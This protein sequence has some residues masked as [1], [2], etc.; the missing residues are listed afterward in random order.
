MKGKKALLTSL[1][2]GLT[3]TLSGC[4]LISYTPKTESSGYIDELYDFLK[5]HYYLEVDDRKLLDGLIYGLTD[6]FN[7][8]FTYYTSS[9]NGESQDYSSSGVGLGFSR[10]LYYG[11]A[12]VSD[13]MK[14][15]PAEKAGLKEND[16]ITKT[17]E[18]YSDGTYGEFYTLKDHDYND[19]SNYF[20]GE[21]NSKI[22]IYV[23]RKDENGKYQD[24]TSP[25]LVTR[26]KYNVDKTKLI[27]FTNTN[28]YSEAYVELSSFLGDKNNNETTPQEELK[29]IFDKDIFTYVDTLDHLIIDLRGNGGGYVDNC[30]NALGLFI[31]KG[32]VT[33][34]YLYAN[35]SYQALKNEKYDYQYT[36][37]INQITLIIDNN[38]ASAG[39][40]FAVGLRD[41]EYT[42]NKVNIVGQVS[43]GKGI[44]QSFVNLF[45]DG[46]LVRYTFARVCS[47]S[48]ECINKR[49][50]VPD[51]F[52]GEE[53][54][55]Y[56]KYVRFIDGVK[57][58]DEL[59]KHDQEVL[60]NRINILTG[61][62]NLTI[63]EGVN[64]LI[65]KYKL[66][67]SKGIYT[68]KIANSLSD[69]FYDNYIIYYG[70]SIYT[71]HVNG[72]NNNDNLSSQQRIFIKEKIN[73]LMNSS[74]QSFDQAIK[75]FQQKYEIENQEHIYDK[76]SADLL[77]GLVMDLHLN[78][79]NV[80]V[81]NQIKE[82][83]GSKK[84]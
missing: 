38:T 73:Y 8:P 55:P 84:I 24:L 39:E 11:E 56:D 60:I 69:L 31:P 70:S 80:E 30:V 28:G 78:N 5:E 36:D 82:A 3:F 77:Q 58:N 15:S 49:G 65:S 13:V 35:G 10:T 45:N 2:L 7:D 6:A 27:E 32:E 22:E 72:V 81:I 47:P 17:R 1:L 25:L 48:K 20:T 43:Y 42:K 57:S 18:V 26:G 63:E 75:A 54:I 51:L 33:A 40:S 9:A 76:V 62:N 46:S 12:Y 4:D 50:I 83:Y 34:Y 59:S 53:N 19:W 23:K 21:E 68:S 79:Y 74:Y 67:D 52:L 71:G 66:E 44:A 61:K 14:N 29:N 16:V 41:S 64:S 37:K